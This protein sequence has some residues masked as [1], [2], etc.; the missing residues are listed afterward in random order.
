MNYDCTVFAENEVC[1]SGGGRFLTTNSITGE[2]TSSLLVAAYRAKP[3]LRIGA[4]IDE[5]VPTFNASGITM[6]K[7]PLYG[8]FGVWNENPNQMGLEARLSASW[9]KQSITQTREVTG[10][11]EAG[12]GTAS[13]NTKALS[14]VLSYAMQVADSEWVASPYLGVRQTKITRGDYTELSSISTPLSYGN[15]TQ[16][17][18]TALAGVRVNR[19]IGD[20][21]HVMASAG[22]EQNTST[23]LSTLDASGVSGLVATDFNADY[24]KTRHVA[25]VGV[26]YEMAKDHRLSFTAMRRKEAFQTTGT[27]TGML[28]YSVGL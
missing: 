7:N 22:V 13:L 2:Q 9:T 12:T 1:V 15:L 6:N 10:T 5:N 8:V 4:F 3:T 17:I 24:A 25:S 26:T 14:G 20:D 16:N 21:F 19:K 18:T 27:T 23:R 11:A 28:M